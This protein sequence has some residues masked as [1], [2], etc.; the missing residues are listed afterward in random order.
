[1]FP[2]KNSTFTLRLWKRSFAVSALLL[3]LATLG[4][5]GCGGSKPAGTPGTDPNAV[6]TKT[7]AGGGAPMAPDAGPAKDAQIQKEAQEGKEGG[8]APTGGKGAAGDK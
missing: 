8:D 3:T 1:M 2:H 7:G 4:L 6:E 5:V